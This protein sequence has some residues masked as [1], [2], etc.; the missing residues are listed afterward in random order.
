MIRWA[1]GCV[2]AALLLAGCSDRSA[3]MAEMSAAGAPP[4][5]ADAAAKAA[6][7]GDIASYLAYEHTVGIALAAADMAAR[8][9]ALQAAC[10]ERRFGECAVLNVWQQGGDHPGGSIGVRIVPS[11]VEPMI[12]LASGGAEIGSRSTRAEDLAVVVRDNALAQDRLRKELERLNAFQARRD[13]AVADM[14]ALSERLAA[15]EAQ[16]E[17]AEREAAQHRRRIDTQLLTFNFS[18]TRT[19]EAQGEV[20]RALRDFGGILASG[21][22]WTIRAAA[23]LLPLLLVLALLVAGIRRWRRRRRA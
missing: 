13:L 12:A 19:Q 10:N 6:A 18:A 14:I 1:A 23:F 7:D 8:V 9:D 17:A 21:T 5:A 4:M 3:P 15:T 16:L 20:G 22:A 2:A 11:G